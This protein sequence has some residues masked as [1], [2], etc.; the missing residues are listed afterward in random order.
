[1]KI[2]VN[3]WLIKDLQLF[4]GLYNC[5]DTFTGVMSALQ[6]HIF[7][8]N[9]PNF[10][11]S[12][13]NVTEVLTTNYEQLDTWSIRKNKPNT[14]PIQTQFKANQSQNKP[15]TNPN[16]PNFK[17]L[18]QRVERTKEWKLDFGLSY[19]FGLQIGLNRAQ[20]SEIYDLIVWLVMKRNDRCRGIRNISQRCF[21]LKGRKNENQR[22]Y[23]NFNCSDYLLAAN[24]CL[25]GGRSAKTPQSQ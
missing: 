5:R 22:S 18:P 23:Q 25:V 3:P 1:V 24:I 21:K 10:R 15:N 16:K 6:N 11:K 19:I 2:S 17:I 7:L 9:K 12:Q 20:Y 8:Q 14:K 4:K 13:V